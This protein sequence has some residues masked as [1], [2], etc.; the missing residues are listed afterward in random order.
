MIKLTTGPSPSVSNMITFSFAGREFQTERVVGSLGNDDGPTIVFIGG[1]HGNE[2]TGVIAI[3]QVINELAEQ[4]TV[5]TGRMIGLVGNMAALKSSRRFASEDLNRLWTQ[6]FL[7]RWESFSKGTLKEPPVDEKHEQLELFT[8]LEPLINDERFRPRKN[9]EPQLYF[10][11]LHTTSSKSIPFIA[12][13]DQIDNRRFGLSFPVPLV[14]GIEEYLEGPLLSLL[15]DQGHVALAFEAGQHEDPQSLELHKSFIYTALANAGIFDSGRNGHLESCR[16]RLNNASQ[17]NHGI[18]E[19]V[20]RKPVSPDDQFVMKPGFTNFSK[21]RKGDELANDRA[22][23]IVAYRNG[24]IL[25][26]LYQDSGNDGFFIV[27]NVPKWALAFSRF[28][29]RINFERLLLLLP[30]V[31]R[32]KTQTDALVVNKKVARFLSVEI[33]HLLGYRR[34]QDDGNEMIVSRREIEK[35]D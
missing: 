21:I 18:F 15:N 32:S 33:F 6:T 11:D 2:P 31:S 23:A 14:L 27:R 5:L 26:P 24:K 1:M 9:T 10:A 8:E 13:N 16:D 29:K 30:G 12:I 19:V 4:G 3:Q 34:K 20:Y 28:L 35:S 25:M 17:S 22:G 7:R